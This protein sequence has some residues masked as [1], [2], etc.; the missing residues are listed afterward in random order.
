MENQIRV[1][2]QYCPEKITELLFFFFYCSRYPENVTLILFADK[3]M[4]N[5]LREWSQKL[6]I[7]G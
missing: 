4:K 7:L 1:S 2:D 5:T 6:Q 3:L